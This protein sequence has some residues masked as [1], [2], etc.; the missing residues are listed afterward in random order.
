MPSEK[1]GVVIAGGGIGGL[2]AAIALAAQGMASTVLERSN[3]GDETGAGIQL[4]PNAARALQKLDLLD[5]VAAAA[6][7]PEA[8]CLFDAHSGR[9]L[10]T[11]PLGDAI[12][13]RY[14]VPYL[15]L[16]RAD[17]HAA[18]YAKARAVAEIKP[19]A[20]ILD[21]AAVA[22]GIDVLTKAGKSF[23]SCLV[24]ADGIWSMVR[25]VVAPDAP[26][27]FGE[28]TAWRTLL[29]NEGLPSPFGDNVVGVWMG[30]GAH[31][32]HYPVRNGRQVNAVVVIDQGDEGVG[33][34]RAID[35]GD[36]LQ[37]IGNW[38]PEPRRLLEQAVTW[39]GWALY[40]LP[41]LTSWS[42][43]NVVLLGDAAHPVLPFLAQGA[44]LAIEDA[45]TLATC[46]AQS[47][48]LPAAF[49]RYEAVRKPRVTQVQKASWRFGRIYHA[50]FPLRASRNIVLSARRGDRLLTSFDWLYG[51]TA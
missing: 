39:R 31:L 33:W 36:L 3:F 27:R 16:H 38:A 1:R 45:V 4:G 50:G 18:L 5:D 20:E 24:G 7:R 13:Q 15:T 23:G 29:I 49:R 2:S 48:S 14:G 46:M 6:A 26:L 42:R 10:S 28:A 34:H 21:I 41:P 44:A 19:G 47:E 40:R 32:V 8:I 12:L 22:D 30:R 11:M 9:R 43:E 35:A 25:D 17:L 51:G 37:R